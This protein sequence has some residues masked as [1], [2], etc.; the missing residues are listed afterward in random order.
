MSGR[1]ACFDYVEASQDTSRKLAPELSYE[2]M[3][4]DGAIIFGGLIAAT[5]NVVNEAL[6]RVFGKPIGG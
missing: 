1:H 6:I 2:E 5:T 3:P 4:H